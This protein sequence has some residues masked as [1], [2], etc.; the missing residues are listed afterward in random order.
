MNDYNIYG[1]EDIKLVLVHGGPGARGSMKDLALMLSDELGVLEINQTKCSIDELIE[2]MKVCIDNH[3][4]EQFV[5]LGHS[6]G[7]WL[8]CLYAA[9]YPENINKLVLVGSGCFNEDY[10][11]EFNNTRMSRLSPKERVYFD[12]LVK[13]LNSGDMSVKNDVM[14]KFGALMGK[15]DTYAYIENEQASVGQ[16]DFKM[17]D[18]IW[19]EASSLR[20][21]GQL[22]DIVKCLSVPLHV[23]Q[24]D[25]DSHNIKGIIEPFDQLDI[26]YD[27]NLLTKCGHYPWREKYAKDTFI[28]IIKGISC[29]TSI[30]FTHL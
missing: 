7:A 19:S 25:Y 18:S 28:E 26:D 4:K 1:E 15:L 2:D 27:F 9:R 23:V 22:L 16:G 17:Y 30:I 10:V 13:E 6:W 21:N 8:I 12:S 11:R 29:L 20:R 24:G 14:K 5:L 3:C